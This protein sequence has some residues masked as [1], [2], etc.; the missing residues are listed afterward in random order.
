MKNND[1]CFELAADKNG[2]CKV[3]SFENVPDSF[4][5]T[6]QSFE[7]FKIETQKRSRTSHSTQRRSGTSH[8]DLSVDTK[9]NVYT[10]KGLRDIWSFIGYMIW[11]FLRNITPDVNQKVVLKS[12][13]QASTRHSLSFSKSWSVN[14]VILDSPFCSPTFERFTN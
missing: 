14:H 3:T 9:D 4:C 11:N 6:C 2:C 8:S 1:T 10:S 12:R 7:I 13:T 5:F